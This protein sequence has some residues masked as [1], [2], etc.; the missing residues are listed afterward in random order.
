MRK[1]VAV[2]NCRRTDF[3][4]I[5]KPLLVPTKKQKPNKQTNMQQI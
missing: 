2:L 4:V 3:P 5:L 1:R